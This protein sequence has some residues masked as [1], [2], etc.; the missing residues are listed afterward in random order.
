ARGPAARLLVI[1]QFP[2]AIC[3]LL[4]IFRPGIARRRALA[5]TAPRLRRHPRTKAVLPVAQAGVGRVGVEAAQEIRGTGRVRLDGFAGD[6]RT[7]SRGG[8]IQADT[9]P[10]GLLN[11]SS[12][13]RLERITF[14]AGTAEQAPEQSADA[15]R[16]PAI[17]VDEHRLARV[18][19][20]RA[21][22]VT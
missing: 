1:R 6:Q 16:L 17:N 7:Q 14:L 19:D 18:H 21:V 8:A 4:L 10:A 5:L 20:K 3:S 13:R 15:A 9:H 12:H 2:R 22:A 11:G